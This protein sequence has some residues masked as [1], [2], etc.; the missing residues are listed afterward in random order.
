MILNILSTLPVSFVY[1]KLFN[2][3]NYY[4]NSKLSSN[5]IALTHA[6]LTLFLA[7][8]YFFIG[9]N[10]VYIQINSGGYF[11]YDTYYILTHNNYNLL[12][13]MYIYHHI[14]CYL[15]ILL[16][17]TNHYWIHNMFFAELSNLSNYYVYYN[18]Q[19]DKYLK[20]KNKSEKTIFSMK[21]QLYSYALIRIFIIGYYGLLEIKND[22]IP[23][24]IYMTSIL[25]IFGLI[26]FSFM[27]IQNNK[28]NNK[29]KINN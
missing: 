21:I 2:T 20:L 13:C 26:W 16:D 15:Y 18:I 5:Y 25:Y 11:L 12:N 19:V 4:E 10:P 1:N 29:L 6:A 8:S 27:V 9:I 23:F 24:V 14:T 7:L 28:S 22:E 17:P 3:Y